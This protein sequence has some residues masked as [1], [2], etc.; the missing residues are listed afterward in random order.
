MLIR[1]RAEREA[2]ESL[3]MILEAQKR[4]VEEELEAECGL[5][6]DKYALLERSEKREAELEDEVAVLQAD[7]DLLDSQLDRALKL[8]K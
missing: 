7:L 2:L 4:K 3:K 5:A 6:L 8:R 1:E